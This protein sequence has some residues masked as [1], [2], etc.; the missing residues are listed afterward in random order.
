MTE[1]IAIVTGS[2]SGFGLLTCI[3]LAKKGFQVIATMRNLAKGD[4]L[5]QLAKQ[6]GVSGQITLQE[7]DV[8]HDASITQLKSYLEGVG[9][10]DVL[11]NNAGYAGAGFVE[12]VPI[13]EYREQFETNVF[14]V[15]AVT[16]AILPIMRTQ[17]SGKII[18]VSSISGRIGFPGLS[19]Y[20]ASKHALEGLSECLR[21]EMQP[22]GVEVVLVE[23]GSYKT[24]IWSTGKQVTEKSLQ[25]SSPYYTYMRKIE[26][27][28]E[29]GEA[30]F[31]NPEE[32]ATKIAEIAQAKGSTLRYP[33]GKGVKLSVFLK[34]NLAWKRWESIFLKKLN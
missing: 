30:S 23:P 25:E 18:N 17:G 10:V 1:Q 19:P 6:E 22:Y 12:E 20:V 5:L 32:V 8:T 29:K 3:E 4:T 26:N 11:V 13:E 21:L 15:I 16:Q 34:T 7:L 2:S 24:N 31:G 28:L 9:R 27:Q 14:G 33:L